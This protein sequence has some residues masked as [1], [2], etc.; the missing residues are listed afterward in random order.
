MKIAHISDIHYSKSWMFLRDMLEEC[1]DMV[2]QEGPDVVV[3]TGD[4]TDYGLG[5]SSKGS[6]W[7]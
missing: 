5:Q 4:V 1:I 6:R 7:N 2:N 3:I